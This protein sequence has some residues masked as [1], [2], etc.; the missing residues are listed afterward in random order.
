VIGFIKHHFEARI[1]PLQGQVSKLIDYMMS[2]EGKIA[3]LEE[4][5]K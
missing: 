4:K 1:D 5:T 2:H 3:R